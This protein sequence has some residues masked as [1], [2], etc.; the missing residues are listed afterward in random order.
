MGHEQTNKVLNIDGNTNRYLHIL[1]GGGLHLDHQQVLITQRNDAEKMF[2]D[3]FLEVITFSDDTGNSKYI[4]RIY[5]SI[6]SDFDER[7]FICHCFTDNKVCCCK[8]TWDMYFITL[9]FIRSKIAVV[10]S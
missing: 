5:V 10:H 7:R 2:D 9:L 1:Y 3:Q 4:S 6:H 8:L